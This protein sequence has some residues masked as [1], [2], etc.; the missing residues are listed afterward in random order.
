M[1]M[2]SLGFGG[3]GVFDI[4]F[5]VGFLQLDNLNEVTVLYLDFGGHGKGTR[6]RRDLDLNADLELKFSAAKTVI[7]SAQYNGPP[8]SA[9]LWHICD[10]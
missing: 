3:E 2:F 8:Q 9:V 7:P 5:F 6:L 4:F 1:V 10:K